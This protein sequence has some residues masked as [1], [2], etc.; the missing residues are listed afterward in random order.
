M[1]KLKMLK[2][3]VLVVV[4]I[5]AL[6][7]ILNYGL[8]LYLC[9]KGKI[10][11]FEYQVLPRA[12]FN[13]ENFMYDY[14]FQDVQGTQYNKKPS[15]LLF[16]GSMIEGSY[17]EN[18]E[19][20]D[21]YLADFSKRTVYNRSVNYGFIQYAIAQVQNHQI[22]D[23]I[24]QSSHAI[25]FLDGFDN[26]KYL[27][28]YPGSI[29]SP[30]RLLDNNLY[31]TYILNKNGDL[32]QKYEKH[33]KIKGSIIYRIIEKV[34]NNYV[35]HSMYILGVKHLKLLQDELKKIN[36][37][38]ELCLVVYYDR[39]DLKLKKYVIALNKHGIKVIFVKGIS[40]ITLEDPKY[41]K[42]GQ[43][44]KEASLIIVPEIVKAIGL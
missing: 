5:V 40:N 30:S 34:I 31:L 36:P 9:H 10:N 16:G 35:N 11:I 14:T 15:I 29:L 24:K 1:K 32:V 20:F 7:F 3:F 42:E 17:Y 18:P 41:T 44:T 23:Y 38:I 39:M 19:T 8:F 33:P 21:K 43:P 6:I 12:N 2:I 27:K 37:N 26:F 28:V 22:D 25:Y 13:I 4:V